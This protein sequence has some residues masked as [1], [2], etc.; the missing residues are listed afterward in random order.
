MA[1]RTDRKARYRLPSEA[2][3]EYTARGG[4]PFAYCWGADP[5][6]A[7]GKAVCDGCGSDWNGKAQD[8]R[9]ARVDDPGF[10]P[11]GF[12]L[13]HTAGNVWEWVQDCYQ[14]GYDGAPIDGSARE[15]DHAGGC[16]RV[17]R[18]GSWFNGPGA[19][20]GHPT[21]LLPARAALHPRVSSRPGHRVAL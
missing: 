18:G 6:A 13:Y 11:N 17:L 9:T 15:P 3:W 1:E 4:S 5:K 14:D 21:Q 8:E 20:I 7:K 12:G 16:G 19:A 10:E 2:E